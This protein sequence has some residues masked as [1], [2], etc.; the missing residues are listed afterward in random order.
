MIRRPPRSTLFPYTTLFRSSLSWYGAQG[1]ERLDL[2]A[3]L[4]FGRAQIVDSLEIQPDLRA[5]SE[6]MPQP[7][8][9]IPRDRA[10]S[11]EN[12][13]NAVGRH[14]E[15]A[16]EFRR[17]QIQLLELLGE[18]LARMNCRARHGSS[19]VIVDYFDVV[20]AFMRYVKRNDSPPLYPLPGPLPKE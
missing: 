10:L 8:G 16:T 6:E 7:Q 20:S 9:G 18:M 3:H 17:T 13:G 15:S 14:S 11:V 12:A 4:R 5:H 19:S 1:R 2:S